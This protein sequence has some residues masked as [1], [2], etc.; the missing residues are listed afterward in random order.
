MAAFQ[1]VSNEEQEMGC[2]DNDKSC[3]SKLAKPRRLPWLGIV[4]GVL[5]VL[6]VINWQ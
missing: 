4:I 1:A 3:E 5:V 2:C 6:V